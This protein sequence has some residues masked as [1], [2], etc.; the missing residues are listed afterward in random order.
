MRG[1]LAE[2]YAAWLVSNSRL[3]VIA[4]VVLTAVV[5]AGAA[6][7]ETDDAGIGEFEVDGEAADAADYL[8]TNYGTDDQE[9]TQVVVREE[10]GDVLT[11]SS[12]IASLQLQQDARADEAINATLADEGFLG[13]ENVVGTAAVFEERLADGGT[14][15]SNPSHTAQ[16]DALENQSDDE[17]EA[18]LEAVLAGE[19]VGNSSVG[20][21]SGTDEDPLAFLPTEYEPGDTEAESRLTL[22]FHEDESGAEEDPVA[23]YDA[24]LALEEL[25]DQRFADGFVF[26]QGITDEASANATGDSFAIITP[27]AL[28]LVLSILSITYRDVVDV[29][30][31]LAGI[32]I[33]LAWLA[34]L[35]GWLEIPMSQLLIAVPFLLIGLSIDYA[36]HVVMRYREARN[37]TLDVATRSDAASQTADGGVARGIH[38]GMAF[39]LSG[40]V[41]ALAA[42]SFSTGVGFLSNVVSPLSA[43]RDFA[44]LSA[45][46]IFAT[47]LAFGVFVPALKTEVDGLLENRFG[48][49][50]AKPA[51]GVSAGPVNRLLAGGVGLARRAP[52]VV[53]AVAVLVAAGGVY[54]ATGIDTEFNEA[55]F[56]PEDA[57]AWTSVLPG[58]LEPGTYTVSDDA[59]YL[60]DRF[61]DQDAEAEIL[62]R[63]DVTDPGFLTAIENGRETVEEDDTIVLRADDTASV[64]GPL[65]VL[66]DVAAEEASVAEGIDAR[67]T[68]GD[69]VPNDDLAGLYDL[70]FEVDDAAASEVLERTDDGRY[71]SAR[72]TVDV[73]GDAGAQ[74]V[75]AD[76]RALA[77]VVDTD[78]SLTDDEAISAV[79]TGQ[80]VT[81]ADVQD[82]LL[83][84]LVQA[85][86][87]TLAVILVFLTALY[88]LRHRALSLGVITL[89][90]VVAALAWLLGAM[91][92]LEIPF[93]SETAVITSLAIGLGV[94][95]SIHYGERF[96]AERERCDSIADALAATTA[97]TGG[98]L[99]GSAVTTAAGFGVL[100]LA[101]VPPLQRFGTVTGLAIV[102]AFLACLTVLPSL[103]VVRERL[104]AQVSD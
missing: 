57:P 101:L 40:V 95:Y 8:E 65:S 38:T 2:R 84:T 47:F 53:V 45:G 18:T 60:S 19:S 76:V 44:V 35:M 5:A 32:G 7:G 28:V 1:S 97:G 42:A 56:L 68:T 66:E 6:I 21:A 89:A 16:I 67:D 82:A 54:G 98:A 62:I 23:V 77:A 100:A 63:G 33:V 22:L 24:Q 52:L 102:L 17:F 93:N 81:T 20:G 64:V 36:L 31:A 30:L 69:G 43:I 88:W 87:V 14:I 99:L 49:T 10:D 26:G 83:E 85:F 73:S 25:F 15:E 3:V 59:A 13:L 78:D 72:L 11:R 94:D 96:V 92:V 48:R 90:P 74:T 27:V 75:T 51:F 34:G 12:L 58:P 50:R 29:L 61:G 9:L 104:L 37:G 41:L 86:A 39:G 55:D 91:A 79:A 80:P 4:L 70:L 71:E 46:G 103:L